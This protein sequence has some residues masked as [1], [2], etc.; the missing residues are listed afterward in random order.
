MQPPKQSPRAPLRERNHL[1]RKRPVSASLI[2]GVRPWILVTC[3]LTLLALVWFLYG[4]LTYPVI[5]SLPG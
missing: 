2:L 1:V 5:P 4:W 3:A